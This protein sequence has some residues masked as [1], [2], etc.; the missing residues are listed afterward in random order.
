MK[1]RVSIILSV[2]L[3]AV[4]LAGCTPDSGAGGKTI[5]GTVEEILE[6]IYD[7]LGEDVQLP[8]V[9]NAP[10]S[11][12]MGVEND[13]IRITYYLGVTGIP[14]A[15][16]VA[17]EAAIGGAYSICLLRMEKGADIEKAK[18]DIK[19]NVDPRKWICYMA[20]VVI[21]DNIG[22]LVILI[23]TNDETAPGLGQAIYDS[24]KA[25]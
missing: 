19:D 5:E 6:R 16:G 3:L 22:D 7:G 23:M 11:E 4:L 9:M 2:I 10:L 24:F 13:G 17:S 8:F 12:D 15:E 21:V 14:F 20:D 18:K 1:K 25:L